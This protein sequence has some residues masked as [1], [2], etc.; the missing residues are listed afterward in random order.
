MSTFNMPDL[1]EGL[2][3]AELVSWHV[4]V[5]DHV[6]VDQPLLSVE[7]AKAVVEVPS[8]CSGR[9]ARLIGAPGDI[10]KVGAPVVEFFEEGAAHPDSGTV[11]GA[12]PTAL[13]ENQAPSLGDREAAKHP[14]SKASPAARKLAH[15][16]GVDLASIEGK[17]P[18]GTITRTDIEAKAVATRPGDGFEP[19]RGV[20]R[21]MAENMAR[22]ALEVPGSTVTEEVIVGHWPRDAD[23]TL[24][25]IRAITAGCRAEPALNAWFDK[26][27]MARKLHARIDLGIAINTG[28][29]LFAPVLRDVAAHSDGE[30]RGRLE[31]LKRDITARKVAPATLAGQTIT[32]SNFGMLGGRNASLAI[33]PPQV[34]IL[35]AGRIFDAVRPLEEEMRITKVLP[36][37]LTF[38]H[39]VVTGAEAVRF[40]SAAVAELAH[41]A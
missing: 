6:V 11:V 16:L 19:L 3:E 13:P 8:P 18:G 9:I 37:S 25:L 41:T 4:S 33:V 14:S 32:L 2:T 7:T 20:R 10:I 34:A 23:V 12:L 22:S 29:G 38:D 27:R 39:R 35:G 24:R 26:T 31:E 17:G 30:L 1:G 21:A 28:D 36:L 5:G 15:E 40:L